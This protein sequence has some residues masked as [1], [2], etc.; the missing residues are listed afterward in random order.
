MIILNGAKPKI[1]K[2][3]AHG[4]NILNPI[5]KTKNDLDK[6]GVGYI[7][8]I[9]NQTI[10]LFTSFNESGEDIN[11]FEWWDSTVSNYFCLSNSLSGMECS[12]IKLAYTGLPRFRI[13]KVNDKFNIFY[14]KNICNKIKTQILVTVGLKP[15]EVKWVYD[16]HETIDPMDKAEMLSVISLPMGYDKNYCI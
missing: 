15:N 5:P 8:P 6:S 10:I 3:S 1:L 16:H 13:E 4:Y 14:G 12:N 2:V 7:L 11:H 9:R